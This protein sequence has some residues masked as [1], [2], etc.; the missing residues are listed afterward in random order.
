MSRNKKVLI[1]INNLLCGGAQK[2]LVSLLNCL[3]QGYYDLGLLVLNPE[4]AFFDDIPGWIHV[5]KPSKEVGLMY[6]TLEELFSSKIPAGL[7]LK[8]LRA[9]CSMKLFAKNDFDDVQN[10][11]R[12]W[13]GRIKRLDQDYDLAISY[14]DGFS[15]YYVIDKVS[16]AKKIL[17]VHNEYEKLSYNADYDRTY[18]AQADALVTIS[19]ACVKNLKDTFPECDSRIRLLYNLLPI[20]L[21]RKMSAK[22]RPAEYGGKRNIIISVGRLNEQKGFD[23]AIKAS[24]LL[25][26]RGVE[27]AWFI[28]G[29]GELREKLHDQIKRAGVEQK[30][31]LLGLRKNPYPYIRYADLFVQPSRYEGKS[32]VL[33]EAKILCKPIVATNYDTVYDSIRNGENGTI[34]RFEENDLAASISNLLGDVKKKEFYSKNLSE[35]ISND[36]GVKDY[37][38]LFDS[39]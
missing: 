20:A 5:L 17:W 8:A 35:E 19:E 3:D 32:I 7:L 25:Q 39:I 31:H 1:V 36:T 22:G 16:A 12:V 28:I 34:C 14:V 23:L 24:K 21:I 33:D 30:V 37:L 38:E 26:S 18:F 11:W 6:L 29:E 2:S 15:N 9:K 13:R 4:D 27:F 10:L